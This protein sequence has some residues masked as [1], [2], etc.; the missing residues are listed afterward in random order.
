MT[1]PRILTID[2][3]T[4]P[5]LVWTFEL[6]N[7]NI[8]IHQIAEPTRMI[9]FAAKWHGDRRVLFYSE[10]RDG[11]EAMVRAAHTLLDQADV[12]VTY[13]G[14]TFDIPH[15]NREIDLLNVELAQEGDFAPLLDYSPFVSVDLYRV[16]KKHHR[17]MSH[18]LAWITEQLELSGKLGHEGFE[19]WLKVLAGD[20]KAQRVMERYNKRD[21]VTTEE[22]LDHMRSKITNIPAAVLYNDE[23]PDPER[24]TCPEPCGSIN[25]QR[26]GF[27]RTKTRR[28]PR[29]Q[30]QEC[31][32]WFRGTHSDKGA[33]I[34]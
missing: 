20:P 7:V 23:P 11:R 21:V 5:A 6:R 29:F 13:N 30:C 15:I 25:V 8:G 31:G 32:K 17:W 28:Y 10:W 33:P 22:L 19:L 27:S 9:S 16:C 26:R 14:N 18:K 1:G 4:S 12:V 3:E 34:T 2:I 24:P